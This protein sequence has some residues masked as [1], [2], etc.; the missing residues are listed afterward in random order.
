M[1]APKSTDSVESI[2]FGK[3]PTNYKQIIKNYIDKKR[4]GSTLD[5]DKVHFLNVPNK[6]IDDHLTGEEFGYRA[7]ALLPTE[8][9]NKLQANFFLIKNGKVIKHLYDTGLLSLSKKFCNIELL[10]LG[11]KAE[12]A[13][14]T[15]NEVITSPAD[16]NGFKYISCSSKN[17]DIFFALNIEK[18]LLLQQ[19]DGKQIAAFEI[20][21]LSDTYVIATTLDSYISINRISGAM[22]LKNKGNESKATCELTSKQRF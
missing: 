14:A 7:C 5:L 17:N 20:Q 19:H 22:I 9:F 15:R 13:P 2:S 8:G 3:K 12:S 6:Y 16:N 21:Q 1:T 4:K 18:Q 10:A 11:K